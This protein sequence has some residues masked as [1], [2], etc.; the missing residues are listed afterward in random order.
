MKNWKNIL[1]YPKSIIREAIQIIDA[2][3]LKIALVVDD[4][5]KLLGTVSDGDVRRGMLK[6]YSLDEQVSQI[7]NSTPTVVTQNEGRE[8]VLALMRQKQIYQI[9]VVDKAGVLVGLEVIDTILAA[10]QRNNWVVL[11]AG[12]LGSR[13]KHLTK[14]VPK[15]LLKIGNKPILETILESFIDQGFARFFISVNYKSDL[16]ESYFGGGSR[17]GIQIEYLREDKKL[18]TGGALGLLPERPSAPFLVMNGDVLTKVNFQQLLDFHCEHQAEATMCVRE[19]D[20]QVPYG[21]VRVDKHRIAAIEEK[22]VQSFFVNAG[23]YVLEP[24]TLELIPKNDYFDMPSLFEKMV[25]TQKE[26]AVFPVREYWLD[27]GRMD[28]FE[29]AKLEYTEVFK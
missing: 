7:M 23:I 22:P 15:P 26:T 20:F 18:G 8:K 1:V 4:S 5:R 10:P 29:R 19:Y 11:M 12:G 25:A 16:I 27:I 17:W 24:Q 14:D 28:D 6:G 21:V 13:L 3:A 2:G 9:P